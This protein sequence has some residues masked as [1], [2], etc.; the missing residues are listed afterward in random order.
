M[1]YY[2][3][4]VTL[5][6]RNQANEAI[7]PFKKAIELDPKYANAYYQLGLTLIG[8]NQM[9]EAQTYLTK[10]LEL[11]PTGQ[12]ADT[13]KALIEATKNAGPTTYQ[14]PD[15]SKTKTKQKTKN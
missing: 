8:T 5:I 9:A 15:A 3:L 7:E 6:N 13:A 2:N 4:G 1:A 14:N 10:F 12:D 11:V